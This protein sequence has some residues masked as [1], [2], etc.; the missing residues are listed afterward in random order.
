MDIGGQR[1]AQAHAI[2]SGLLLADG[3]RPRLA[4]LLAM[5]LVN[6][7]RP[8]NAGLDFDLAFFPVQP[9][10]AIELGHVHEYGVAAELL[11]AHRVP[12]AAHADSDPLAPGVAHGSG[13]LIHRTRLDNPPYSRR[14]E[15]RLHIVDCHAGRFVG[16]RRPRNARQR[17]RR[18]KVG[19]GREH[20]ASG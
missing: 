20:L 19:G 15:L 2:D 13:H 6:Q 9:H 17:E 3:P 10:H 16:I 12:A 11:A 1:A 4:F 14:V 7:L 5:E 18:A 8:L